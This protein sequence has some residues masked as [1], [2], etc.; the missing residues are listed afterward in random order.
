[1]VPRVLVAKL[2]GLRRRESL[3]RL[4]W[5]LARCL[6]LAFALLVVACLTDWLLDRAGETPWA[7]RAAMTLFQGVVLLTA[8]ALLVVLPLA[9]RP[10]DDALALLVEAHRPELGHR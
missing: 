2:A 10:A 6:A 3:L 9:R 4:A 5:G 1:M 8:V 7:L